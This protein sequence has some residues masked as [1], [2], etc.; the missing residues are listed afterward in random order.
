MLPTALVALFGA[1]LASFVAPCVL[2]LV[3]VYLGMVTGEVGRASPRRALPATVVFV[4]GFGGVF[5]VVGSVAGAV[6]S[7]LGDARGP[8]VRVGGVLLVGFGL[9]MAGVGGRGL[10]R[11]VRLRAALPIGAVVRPLVLGVVFGVAWTPCVGPLLGA[12][13]VAAAGT[14]SAWRGGVALGAYA[15]G[16]G[17]PFLLASAGLS[18]TPALHRTLRRC[19]P[20]LARVGAAFLVLLGI[21]VASGHLGEVV[22]L[23][24]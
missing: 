23:R 4:A 11:S 6:G 15:A 14:G 7:T 17:T 10:Q 19:S 9:V 24:P 22:A 5:V 13:L 1:G 3:P 12:A 20:A 18:W 16:L 8:V 2:P 21:L